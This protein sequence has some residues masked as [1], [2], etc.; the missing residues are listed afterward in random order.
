MILSR[1]LQ[2]NLRPFAHATNEF[3]LLPPN[4]F[5]LQI[6]KRRG[7]RKDGKRV[8]WKYDPQ[9]QW[10][11]GTLN[12]RIAV[13]GKF[14]MTDAIIGCLAFS[15][16]WDVD[17]L[18][19]LP[20]G[21]LPD[22]DACRS[23]DALVRFTLTRGEI[24]L[25]RRLA[26]GFAVKVK[27]RSVPPKFVISGQ[28]GQIRLEMSA[29]NEVSKIVLTVNAE[30]VSPITR[31]FAPHLLNHLR[32]DDYDVTVDAKGLVEMIGIETGLVF[33]TPTAVA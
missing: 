30:I 25:L 4:R 29:L 13:P 23:R 17:N 21:K 7:V 3:F 16:G 22:F 33:L 1:N 19:S 15:Q 31:S 9:G 12:Q 8:G 20:T 11:I 26:K 18:E 5:A 2:R 10:V 14:S 32:P 27:K 28:D 24:T 6:S